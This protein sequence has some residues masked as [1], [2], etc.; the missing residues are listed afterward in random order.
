MTDHEPTFASLL[1][2]TGHT[3]VAVL[4]SWSYLRERQE[5]GGRAQ[6]WLWIVLSI[7]VLLL[8]VQHATGI[9]SALTNTFRQEALVEGWYGT[10]R[11]FQ[12]LLTRLILVSAVVS[13]G[14]LA[15]LLRKQWRRYALA[16]LSLVM[17]TGFGAVQLVSLHD[18]DA[19]MHSLLLGVRLDSWLDFLGLAFAAG[20][21]CWS[22]R[23]GL[24]GRQML[25]SSSRRPRP[26]RC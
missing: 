11:V 23:E 1:L 25:R 15:W 6:P 22:Y 5:P 19:R 4:C 12:A 8:G 13:L 21:V 14:G 3:C 26:Y 24:R 7:P 16:A 2:L 9:G 18:V 10:R 20:G 17:L